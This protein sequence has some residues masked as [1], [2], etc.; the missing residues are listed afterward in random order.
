MTKKN[1]K[2]RIMKYFLECKIKNPWLTSLIYKNNLIIKF[3]EFYTVI[4]YFQ[5]HI[6]WMNLQFLMCMKKNDD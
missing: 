1:D 4:H 5:N 3:F 2:T 6:L